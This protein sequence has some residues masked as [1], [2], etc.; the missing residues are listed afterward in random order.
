MKQKVKKIEES[1][2]IINSKVTVDVFEIPGKG[3]HF[4]TSIIFDV[5]QG[6]NNFFELS[7]IVDKNISN[8]RYE[9]LE[10]LATKLGVKVNFEQ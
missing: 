9:M 1:I 4:S 2:D 8:A 10:K 3:L 6:K 7:E 5:P